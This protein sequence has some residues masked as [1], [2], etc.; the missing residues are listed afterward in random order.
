MQRERESK[1]AFMY[2]PLLVHNLHSVREQ[3]EGPFNGGQILFASDLVKFYRV[4]I[5]RRRILFDREIEGKS[6]RVNLQR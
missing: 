5:K 1:I 2:G 6:S 3:I 4:S